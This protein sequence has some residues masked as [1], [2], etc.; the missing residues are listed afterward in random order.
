M[1]TNPYRSPESSQKTA[2]PE[3][4]PKRR[5]L[6]PLLA[7]FLLVIMGPS[8][9]NASQFLYASFAVRPHSKGVLFCVALLDL[10]GLAIM[11]AGFA[12][13]IWHI[14]NPARLP[15]RPRR[16][17]PGTDTTDPSTGRPP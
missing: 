10:T 8:C 3:C 15:S 12:M 6:R 16:V 14:I 17:R 2:K 11:L 1:S 13:L 7:L 5:W 9:F 4:R